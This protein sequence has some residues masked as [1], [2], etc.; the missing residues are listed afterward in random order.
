M[1]GKLRFGEVRN[2][3]LHELKR[4]DSGAFL[5]SLSVSWR[6]RLFLQSES[7]QYVPWATDTETGWIGK[8]KDGGL[9]WFVA[10]SSERIKLADTFKKFIL[11]NV[12]LHRYK[13]LYGGAF[14]FRFWDHTQEEDII[15]KFW[16]HKSKIRYCLCHWCLNR[17]QVSALK[18]NIRT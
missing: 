6:M 4:L 10:K 2:A 7:V 3:K 9:L 8:E 12:S 15:Q 18:I 11:C 5:C 17:K 13:W 14:W 16:P 1:R